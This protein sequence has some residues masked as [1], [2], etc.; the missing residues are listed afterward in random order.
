MP[1]VL[2]LLL[3]PV[4]FV[5]AKASE[6][7]K[8]SRK[9]AVLL[10]CLLLLLIAVFYVFVF[11][12]RLEPF[13]FEVSYSKEYMFFSG[14]YW[15]DALVVYVFAPFMWVVTV[16]FARIILRT[17][18]VKKNTIIKQ[19]GEY[20]YYRDDL[21]K[22][23]PGIILFTSEMN[24]DMRRCI[25]SG[26]LKLKLSGYVEEKNGRYF[27]TEKTMDRL[28]ESEKLLLQLVETGSLDM[29][30]YRRALESE[31]LEEKYITRNRGGTLLRLLRLLVSACIPVALFAGAIWLS[32]YGFEHYRVY[33]EPVDGGYEV[34]IILDRMEDIERLMTELTDDTH[35]Y[36]SYSVIDGQMHY[37]SNWVK[38]NQFQYGIVRKVYRIRF[39]EIFSMVIAFLSVFSTLYSIAE[40]IQYFRK[41]YRRTSKGNVLLNKAY[42]LKNY[43]KQY[44]LIKDRSEQELLLWEYYL[45]YAVALD[46]NERIEDGMMK[47]LFIRTTIY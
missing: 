36:G 39:L 8:V 41:S 16:H 30:A 47:K 1:I 15:L 35:L 29:A 17:L 45:V 23:A 42:A 26:V 44:S 38:A 13:D 11:L 31:A 28:F 14:D 9:R 46:V 5:I 33:P 2:G 4:V 6:S 19:Q 37:S 3:V 7:P 43:L 25:S 24:V 40:Q 12:T 18:R 21:D 20:Q 27:C 34:Y 10:N 32:D 22:I